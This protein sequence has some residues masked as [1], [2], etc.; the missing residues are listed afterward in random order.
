MAEPDLEEGKSG[1]IK[2]ART[3]MKK[4]A[5]PSRRNS[6]RQPLKPR[7][8]DRPAKI[9]AASKPEKAVAKT[10]PEYKT[11]VRRASSFFV[12]QQESR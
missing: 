5:T 2:M 12:Y 6:H 8:P 7:A 4:V 1:R 11:A 9:P 3:P 10:R